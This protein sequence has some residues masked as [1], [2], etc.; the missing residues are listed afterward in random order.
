MSNSTTTALGNLGRTSLFG[1]RW[2]PVLALLLVIQ[3]V[4]T[5]RVY[6]PRNNAALTGRPLLAAFAAD[7][8]QGVTVTDGNDQ[9]LHAIRRDGGW[10][11]PNAGDYPV[12]AEKVTGLLEKIGGLKRDR[13]VGS[14]NSTLTQL[15][16]ADAKFA[17][18]I[19]LEMADGSR[20]TVYVGDGPRFRTSHVRLG[21]ES[22]AY[23]SL[24]FSTDE[25]AT[26]IQ[27]WIDVSY[28]HIAEASAQ[29]MTLQ[30]A[31]GV[32]DFYRDDQN[33]W[34]MSNLAAGEVFNA[35]NLTALLTTLSSLNLAEPLGREAQPNY[36]LDSPAARVTLEYKDDAGALKQADLRV[37]ALDPTSSYYT[38]YST[39]S[40]YYV[41]ISKYSLER[42]VQRT[43][44][45]FLQQPPTPT[46]QP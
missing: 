37:G 33:Q 11:L 8:V 21:G 24:D 42:F 18:R 34:Q 40:D 45:E 3:L 6:W 36:G 41:H 1:S 17:R 23:L 26:R 29:K 44:Q 30:N 27:D 12:K 32:F 25:S 22:N 2:I 46:P 7:Q 38:V 31:N 4:V 43:R 28:F 13:L 20:Q 15:D 39:E 35:N 5:A 19:E 10:V 16:V 14:K 9:Q